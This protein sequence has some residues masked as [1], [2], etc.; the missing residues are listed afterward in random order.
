MPRY[1]GPVK[2]VRDVTKLVC[3]QKMIGNE[4]TAY[5]YTHMATANRRKRQIA[6]KKTA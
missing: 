3:L 2:V 6:Y 1:C 4:L 5:I